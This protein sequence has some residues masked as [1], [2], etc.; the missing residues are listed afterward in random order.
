MQ[1]DLDV[2]TPDEL[3]RALLR[4][5]QTVDPKVL[6]EPEFSTNEEGIFLARKEEARK[7]HLGLKALQ[8]AASDRGRGYLV[9]GLQEA[10]NYVYSHG[11]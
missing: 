9:Q 8:K 1:R 10:A 5:G 6:L 3:A 4:A 2:F 11:A 7:L